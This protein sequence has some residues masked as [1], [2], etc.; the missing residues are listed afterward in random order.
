MSE[1]TFGRDPSSGIVIEN[2]YISRNHGKMLI[3][4]ERLYFNDFSTNGSFLNQNR[5][6]KG[7][8]VPISPG[9][10][11]ILGPVKGGF[12]VDWKDPVLNNFIETANLQTKSE[13]DINSR[14][15]LKTEPG[16]TQPGKTHIPD[17]ENNSLRIGRGA[18]CDVVIDDYDVSQFHCDIKFKNADNF[19]IRDLGSRNRTYISKEDSSRFNKVSNIWIDLKR[20]DRI[21]LGSEHILDV[22]Y[23]DH[24]FAD[25]LANQIDGLLNDKLYKDGRRLFSELVKIDPHHI[26]VNKFRDILEIEG[27]RKRDLLISKKRLIGLASVGVV[28]VLLVGFF[29]IQSQRTDTMSREWAAKSKL[30]WEKL[31]QVWS[32]ELTMRNFFNEKIDLGDSGIDGDILIGKFNEKISDMGYKQIL[33][34]EQQEILKLAFQHDSDLIVEET[35]EKIE[36]LNTSAILEIKIG[37]ESEGELIVTAKMK[38]NRQT[39]TVTVYLNWLK[40]TINLGAIK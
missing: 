25:I 17:R 30:S 21:R 1:L 38:K 13:P 32:E 26:K 6:E 24:K 36:F 18:D 7:K 29:L 3:K 11:L 22:E 31:N 35:V 16:L 34:P 37:D 23:F 20:G 27:K 15:S 9:A 33:D 2:D 28:G 8:D 19:S 39:R 14:T 4:D 12:R 10:N 5:L 40:N